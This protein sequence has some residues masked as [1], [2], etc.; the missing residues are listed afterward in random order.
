MN[1]KPAM[2]MKPAM[3]TKPNA[4]VY[5][6]VRPRQGQRG[7][8]LVEALFAVAILALCIQAIAWTG[9]L[10]YQA[11][12]AAQ[13]GR[14]AAFSA[15]RGQPAASLSR[16]DSL[17][18]LDSEAAPAGAANQGEG[19]RLSR[20]WLRADERLLRARAE[21]TVAARAGLEQMRGVDRAVTLSRHT[22]VARAGGHAV[23]DA[24]G[25]SRLVSSP[26]GWGRAGDVSLRLA[27]TVNGRAAQA[28]MGW[29]KREPGSDWVSV[30][31]D[32]V[33]SRGLKK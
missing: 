24:D 29:I 31:A 28:E 21:R 18:R 12:A 19:A 8:G 20:E 16:A 15:A 3:N 25:Q 5:G 7:Q 32:L 22:A 26:A 30:W 13:D 27:R 14:A 9:R 2:N 1:T 11:M 10:Q 6:K 33:P 17:L 23:S 4:A